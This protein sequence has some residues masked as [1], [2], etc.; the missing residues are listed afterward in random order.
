MNIL[1]K[2]ITRKLID[3]TNRFIIYFFA[4]CFFII[5]Y[6]VLK[7][8]MFRESEF[9]FYDKTNKIKVIIYSY[10][11]GALGADSKKIIVQKDGDE[12]YNYIRKYSQIT[13]IEYSKVT[14]HQSNIIIS[15]GFFDNNI[16]IKK[17]SATKYD[18]LGINF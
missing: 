11:M 15:Y 2:N 5:V 13:N 8:T 14:K 10:D 4:L 3:Y 6:F 18:T 1:N 16:Y 12:I 9:E 7:N 17:Y